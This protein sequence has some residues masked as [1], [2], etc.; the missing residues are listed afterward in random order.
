MVLPGERFLALL[1]RIGNSGAPFVI[2]NNYTLVATESGRLFLRINEDTR[3][4]GDEPGA[5]AVAI[6]ALENNGE[7]SEDEISD[8]E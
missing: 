4:A 6:L 8:D 3:V 1:G 7:N 2:G 5:Y